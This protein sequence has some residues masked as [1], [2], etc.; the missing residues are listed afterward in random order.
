[1][2]IA[3]FKKETRH[4]S[5]TRMLYGPF[6]SPVGRSNPFPGSV[7]TVRMSCAACSMSSFLRVAVRSQAV[8][9]YCALVA[10]IGV[11]RAVS[12]EQLSRE[13]LKTVAQLLKNSS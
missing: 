11:G 2:P 6:R 9:A 12:D 10:A 4:W 5:L 13:I 7:E 1:M 8:L 3:P